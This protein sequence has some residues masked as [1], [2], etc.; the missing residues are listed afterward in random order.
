LLE[1]HGAWTVVNGSTSVPGVLATSQERED[2]AAANCRAKDLLSQNVEE[3]KIVHLKAH[4]L[5]RD[6]KVEL[7][8]VHLRKSTTSQA[9]LYV[10]LRVL[11]QHEGESVASYVQ[12]ANDLA[13]ELEQAGE[14][15]GEERVVLGSS[16]ECWI[17]VK[18]GLQLRASGEGLG[19]GSSGG[20]GLPITPRELYAEGGAGALREGRVRQL[21][22]LV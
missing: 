22:A 2:Y 19:S 3:D 5:A 8:K 18:S 9:H 6:V 15:V 13:S 7:A 16:E 1:E 17:S 10:Q 21:C 12:R 11:A 14:P 4:E 20:K